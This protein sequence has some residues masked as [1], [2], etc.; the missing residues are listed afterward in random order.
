MH[1]WKLL[2]VLLPVTSHTM[3]MCTTWL[4]EVLG[5]FVTLQNTY[6]KFLFRQLSTKKLLITDQTQNIFET[7][8]L[9]KVLSSKYNCSFIMFHRFQG[10]MHKFSRN[11][12]TSIIKEWTI[13]DKLHSLLKTYNEPKNL[14]RFAYGPVR[15]NFWSYH[16]M[17]LFSTGNKFTSPNCHFCIFLPWVM[18]K[19]EPWRKW[20]ACFSNSSI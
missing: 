6:K 9:F 17:C 18:E 1:F 20:Y 3:L 8:F 5:H 13:W 7:H 14:L 16:L 19:R 15:F 11:S 2:H 4:E 12:N 10:T